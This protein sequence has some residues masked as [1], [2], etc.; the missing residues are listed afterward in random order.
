[1][2]LLC[3]YSV[4]MW[5]KFVMAYNKCMKIF[6]GYKKYHSL[7]DVFVSL[8]L[9]TLNTLLL[10]AKFRLSQSVVNHDNILVK[11]VSNMCAVG[12]NLL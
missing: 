9:P 10:N 5:K 4:Y 6:F 11:F 3:N 7:T 1:M 8:K 12:I 2:A